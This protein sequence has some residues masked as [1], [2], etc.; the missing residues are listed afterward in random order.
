MMQYFK[1]VI[2]GVPPSNNKYMG[3]SNSFREY[4]KEKEK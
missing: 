2:D 3:N 4:G 1:Y